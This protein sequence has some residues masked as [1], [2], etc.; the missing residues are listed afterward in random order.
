MPRQAKAVAEIIHL[1]GEVPTNGGKDA[2]EMS[3]PYI[4]QVTICGIADYLYHRW[5]V[6]SVDAKA[7]AARGSNAKK[8]DDLESYVYRDDAGYLCIPGLQI[9]AAIIKSAKFKTDPRSSRKSAEDLYKAGVFVLTHLA[10]VG[11]KE[12]DYLDRRRMVVQRQGI[13]R[14]RPALKT[15]WTATFEIQVNLP[16]Y[17]TPADLNDRIGESGRLLGIGDS[18]P[19]YGRFQVTNFGILTTL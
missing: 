17:I 13:T 15:G 18:R 11:K 16:E 1:G 6:E 5:N 2:I 9:Q 19:S 14:T 12:W 10:S 8:T 4:A 7:K 3:V